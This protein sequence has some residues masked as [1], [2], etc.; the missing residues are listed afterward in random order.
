LLYQL[1]YGTLILLVVTVCFSITGAKVG[2]FSELANSLGA[3]FK[4]KF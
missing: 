4:K 1:S 2:T 3:F